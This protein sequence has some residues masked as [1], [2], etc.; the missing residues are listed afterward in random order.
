MAHTDSRPAGLTPADDSAR[1]MRVIVAQLR[2]FE[3]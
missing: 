2:S 1:R 3:M